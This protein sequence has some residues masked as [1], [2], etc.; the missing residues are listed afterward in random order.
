VPCA[1][2]WVQFLLKINEYAGLFL[3]CLVM[4]FCYSHSSTVSFRTLFH[5]DFHIVAN[6]SWILPPP[7]RCCLP[8]TRH[9]LPVLSHLVLLLAW[10]LTCL[11]AC[12][13]WR[14]LQQ[15]SSPYLISSLLFFVSYF[16]LLSPFQYSQKNV[17]TE[18][19]QSTF[20]TQTLTSAVRSG[21]QIT[22]VTK[23]NVIVSPWSFSYLWSVRQLW[24]DTSI[25][26][27]CR[28]RCLKY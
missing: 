6:Y 27:R 16:R 22:R 5:I 21:I 26:I 20:R 10:F 9:F 7:S 28:S 14:R 25:V 13:M 3:S 24:I 4:S 1:I 8:P 18:K 2:D 15:P 11:R 12:G 23:P 17:C 19:D